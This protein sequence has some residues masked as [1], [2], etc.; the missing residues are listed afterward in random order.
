[1]EWRES[2]EWTNG[3]A[4]HDE[5]VR[6]VASIAESRT[7]RSVTNDINPIPSIP[8][9]SSIPSI[10]PTGHLLPYGFAGTDRMNIHRA[11]SSVSL[12]SL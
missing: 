8:S 1:M 12:M 2:S 5:H 11:A 7:A 9:I 4:T 3:A 10:A 6:D